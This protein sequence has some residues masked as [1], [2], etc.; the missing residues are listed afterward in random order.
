MCDIKSRHH[1]WLHDGWAFDAL[2]SIKRSISRRLHDRHCLRDQSASEHALEGCRSPASH[3][4]TNEE[5]SAQ[6]APSWISASVTRWKLGAI[7]VFIPLRNKWKAEKGLSKAALWGPFNEVESQLERFGYVH[8]LWV[9]CSSQHYGHTFWLRKIIGNTWKA[10]SLKDL[11]IITDQSKVRPAAP[12][13][14]NLPFVASVHSHSH[15]QNPLFEHDL[16]EEQHRVITNPKPKTS[17]HK[18]RFYI[19]CEK[20]S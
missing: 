11:S 3:V 13:L 10:C 12:R 20:S 19:R 16:V 18:P 5:G 1:P 2:S 7:R 14:P 17:V 4:T 8:K 6:L 15:R 9:M